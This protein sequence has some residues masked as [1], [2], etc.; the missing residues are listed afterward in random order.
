MTNNPVFI[1]PQDQGQANTTT[2]GSDSCGYGVIGN[3][4]CEDE[5]LTCSKWGWCLPQ[6]VTDIPRPAPTYDPNQVIHGTETPTP[7]AGAS[8]E[9]KS[10]GSNTGV[11]GG[12]GAGVLCVGAITAFIVLRR[13]R[14]GSMISMTSS[15]SGDVFGSRVAD[16]PLYARNANYV[17]NPL[18]KVSSSQEAV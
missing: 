8:G 6:S 18:Y 15:E 9:T 17:E 1:D 10:T 13:N 4:V 3:G 5:L 2:P 11:A 14:G 12:V 16:N 7:S